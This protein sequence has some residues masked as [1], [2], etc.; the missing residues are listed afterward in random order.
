MSF[1]SSLPPSPTWIMIIYIWSMYGVGI[2]M[3]VVAAI[4]HI[5][6]IFGKKKK[7]MVLN[8][9]TQKTKNSIHPI[10]VGGV[11][12]LPSLLEFSSSW[13]PC[14]FSPPQWSFFCLCFFSYALR[15][16]NFARL[17]FCSFLV[18][19]ADCSNH[20][21]C[22]CSFLFMD[23]NKWRILLHHLLNFLNSS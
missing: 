11:Y 2:S 7:K 6:L 12:F 15:I 13:S 4:H 5:I 8:T 17:R 21:F 22:N 3:V 14:P 19:S 20:T 9:I 10:M 18:C 1:S 23:K 16:I